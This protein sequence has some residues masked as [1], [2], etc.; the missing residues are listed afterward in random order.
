MRELRL[1]SGLLAAAALLAAGCGGTTAQTGAGASSIVPASAP[2]F[3]SIDANPNSQQWRTIDAL[4]SKFP[5]KQQA[6]E[7]I[8]DELGI[9]RIEVDEHI[10]KVSLVGAGMKTHPGVA[11]K[12][13]RTLGERNVNI[14][15]IVTSPIK[16]SC[17]IHE[18]DVGE[19]VRA[20]HT[21]FELDDVSQT[22]VPE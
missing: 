14:E 13:F 20:L 19:A 4:A 8:K 6:L 3:L 18:K 12:A 17:V 5:D 15:M 16:I 21:A 1:F 10:G 22:E 2:A 11:A 7:S 9:G